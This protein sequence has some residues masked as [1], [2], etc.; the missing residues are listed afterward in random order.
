ME[1]ASTAFARAAR[2]EHQQRFG[3]CE[4]Q[5]RAWEIVE[6]G[7]VAMFEES[8]CCHAFVDG[9]ESTQAA[10]DR[11]PVTAGYGPCSICRWV[12]GGCQGFQGGGVNCNYCGHPFEVHQ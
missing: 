11:G 9:D 1:K 6:E 12:Q 3:L 7:R 5:P 10:A 8:R 4:R 2:P